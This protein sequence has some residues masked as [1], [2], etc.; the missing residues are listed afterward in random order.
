LCDSIDEDEHVFVD[1]D[2]SFHAVTFSDRVEGFFGD[3]IL[4]F[5]ELGF[6]CFAIVG[7]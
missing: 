3:D 4:E 2:K 5:L 6:Y 1:V 7:I